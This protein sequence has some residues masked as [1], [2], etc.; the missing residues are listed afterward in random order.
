MGVS[1]S[2]DRDLALDLLKG[3]LVVA[4]VVYHTMN[5]FSTA[6]P[7]AFA[8]VRF[9][10][11]SFILVAGYAVAVFYETRFGARK[12]ETSRRLMA[13]GLKLFGVF[14][15]LNALIFASGFG[16]PTKA[17]LGLDGAVQSLGAIYVFG[18]PGLASFQILLPIAYFLMAAPLVLMFAPFARTTFAFALAIAFVYS[19]LGFQS[20]NLAF[21]LLGV[22]GVCVGLVFGRSISRAATSGIGISVAAIILCVAAMP[23]LDTNLMAYAVGVLALL[24]FTYDLLRR[25]DANSVT[26][27]ALVVL[28]QYSLLSDIGQILILQLLFRAEGG[29]K[30]P[31][32]FETATV[33]PFAVVLLVGCAALSYRRDRYSAIERSY[34][35]MFS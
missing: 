15:V 8:Y 20:V 29:Q 16:N 1:Q 19:V 23:W 30:G 31:L 13:R 12:A 22:I 21:L 11:G 17:R 25:L 18:E 28:G 33:S 34:R 5:I 35:L 24:R 6:G 27:R 7:E 3:L 9:V 2:S 14:T 26:A 4:M 10:S 32:G